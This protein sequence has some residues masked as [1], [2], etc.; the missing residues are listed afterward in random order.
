MIK[1]TL[2][3]IRDFI[4]ST[5]TYFSKGYTDVFVNQAGQIGNDKEIVF[6]SDY[7]GN[8]FYIRTAG[9]SPFS[10]NA[11]NRMSDCSIA[12]SLGLNCILVATMKGA[13]KYRLSENLIYTLQKYTNNNLLLSNIT[14]D[15]EDVILS[16]LSG[17]GEDVQVEAL[18]R[19]GD[20]TIVSIAFST[21]I[22]FSPKDL[23]CIQNPCSCS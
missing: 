14:L 22:V 12:L 18:K 19:S 16:E 5:N 10:Q 13:D 3:G 6:P 15:K 1:E 7:R 20:Y 2:D 4:L 9:N 11:N 8:Y 21:N 17:A 23:S